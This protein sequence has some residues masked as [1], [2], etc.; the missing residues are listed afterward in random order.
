MRAVFGPT[1]RH[2]RLIRGTGDD[3]LLTAPGE[4]LLKAYEFEG[5]SG[6]KVALAKYLL[7]LEIDQ[8]IGV[9]L[10]IQKMGKIVSGGQLL[11]YLESNY[12][13]KTDYGSFRKLM[14]YYAY[15]GLV[16]IDGDQLEVR[17]QQFE[18]LITGLE[19]KVSEPQFIRVLREEYEKIRAQR[20]GNPYVPIPD[21]RDGVCK[22]TGIMMGRFD[23]M[24]ERIPKETDSYIIHLSQP[25]LRKAGGIKL[26]GKYLYYVSIYEKGE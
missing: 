16:K 19:A 20:G 2:L 18:N 1:L 23:Q 24:L 9:M 10:D 7:K 15:V 21:V 26:A 17:T 11:E 25:M 3:V 8:G 22:A 14:L 13:Q 6:F 4:E 5:E 12:G